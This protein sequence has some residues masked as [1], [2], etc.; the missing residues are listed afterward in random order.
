[1]RILVT[2]ASKH[3]ATTE[4]ASAIG[5]ALADAGMEVEVKPIHDLSGV[6][7]WN[8]VVLGSAVY[9]GRWLPEATEFVERH[10]VELRARPVWL[11]S[12]GPIGSP[13][14]KPDGDPARIGEL[15]A[16]VHARGHR[17]FAGRLDRGQLGIGEKLVLSAVQAPDGD[18]RDWEALT[19]WAQEI[20]A[21]LRGVPAAN[22]AL[23]RFPA[24]AATIPSCTCSWS[25]TTPASDAS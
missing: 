5:K 19:A 21:A 4:M 17:T 8:A 14:P 24:M 2:A 13:D 23:R 6:A 10:A 20:A 3:G 15:V 7:G 12:S 16:A 22:R 18:F 11:F 1:M 25:R 9:M